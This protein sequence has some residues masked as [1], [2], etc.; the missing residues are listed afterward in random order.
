MPSQ[1]DAQVIPTIVIG[2]ERQMTARTN[3]NLQGYA[4]K[5][6]YKREQTDLDELL[7]DKF[8]L[9]LG[10]RHR[11]DCCVVVV[12]RHR[13]SAEPQQHAGHR[14]PDGIRL[15]ADDSSLAERGA[16]PYCVRRLRDSP[17]RPILASPARARSAVVTLVSPA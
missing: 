1:H 2:W 4:S 3:L 11:F 7:S 8:Q 5:S 14:I 16:V 9:S 15:G 17:S 10:V 6:V 13:E 12:R